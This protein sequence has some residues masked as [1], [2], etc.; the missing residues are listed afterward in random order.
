MCFIQNKTNRRILRICGAS[1]DSL[2]NEN[3]EQMKSMPQIG[4]N[5]CHVEEEKQSLAMNKR[6]AQN[7][8]MGVLLCNR[9]HFYV[10]LF[11]IHLK[12][13]TKCSTQI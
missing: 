11:T 2:S 3:S 10:H 13:S 12:S 1:I 9:M 5:Q 8:A 7:S 4:E 6:R